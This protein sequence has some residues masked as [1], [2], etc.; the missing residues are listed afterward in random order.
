MSDFWN[1]FL[2]R[3]HAPY[4][5]VPETCV[6]VGESG[7]LYPGIRLENASYPLTIEADQLGIALCLMYDDTPK[8]I[9][10]PKKLT[11]PLLATFL[12]LEIVVDE[13]QPDGNIFFPY[14]TS[15]FSTQD[16]ITLKSY[17]HIP[18]SGFPVTALIKTDNEWIG[19]ANVEFP[20]WGSGLCGERMALATALVLGLRPDKEIQIKVFKGGFASP[21]GACRQVLN[22][23]APKIRVTT[24]Q[25]DGDRSV[26]GLNELLP[27]AF[28]S[29]NLF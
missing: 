1:T 11:A 16:L 20:H 13:T 3:S 17:C 27:Y 18:E 9:V 6:C 25:K 8:K 15:E 24:H 7:T 23:F 12:E 22:E 21:C 2:A 14:S 26:L 28:I 10:A 19:G 4:S 29:K 5:N